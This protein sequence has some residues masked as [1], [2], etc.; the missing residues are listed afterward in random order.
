MVY[1]ISALFVVDIMLKP[2]SSWSIILEVKF[3]VRSESSFE[4]AYKS[5][6]G[7]TELSYLCLKLKFWSDLECMPFKCNW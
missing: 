3:S 1:H 5:L 4:R 6:G 2:S 7:S